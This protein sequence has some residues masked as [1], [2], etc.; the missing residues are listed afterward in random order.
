MTPLTRHAFLQV[1]AAALAT[2]ARAATGPM[3]TKPIPRSGEALPVIGLGTSQVFAS[4]G[5]ATA[6]A[7]KR[8]VVKALIDGGATCIDTAP[9][10][11][12]AENVTGTLLAELGL[13]NK[14][15]IATKIGIE[16]EAE[17]KAQL[18]NS[19]LKLRTDKLDLVQVHNLRDTATQLGT[20]RTAK[21]EGKVRY[22]GITHSR[23]DG[24]E[25]LYDVM[26][27]EEVDF[28]QL[29]YSVDV[30][31]PEQRLLP[32]ARDKGIAV[33]VNLPFGRGRLIGKMQGK[34][35]P[36]F[37]A[38]I[39]CTTHAQL[40]LKFV[41]AHPA[42]TCAIPATSKVKHMVENLDAGRGA[43]P[44]AKLREEIAK[45]WAA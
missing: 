19:F 37:A 31:G 34:P 24:Q 3:S 22:T 35:L 6:A 41:I 21:A 17:G 12:D 9:S 43:M 33:L 40:L 1:A 38:E 39:G 30:R 36:G 25:A 23:P 42:V 5:D 45:L 16:G 8:E 29:N 2:Q 14:T 20:L 11:A 10:Y 13:R 32:L 15:F 7:A 18:A 4:M 26:K 44:D 27:A 28:V